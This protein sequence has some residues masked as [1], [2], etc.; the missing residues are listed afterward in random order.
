MHARLH[1]VP[2]RLGA[3]AKHK[4]AARWVGGCVL[5]GRE[6]RE[7]RR[8][9]G[10]PTCR[11]APST[12]S[13]VCSVPPKRAQVTAS[14]GAAPAGAPARS[15]MRSARSAPTSQAVLPSARTRTS[16]NEC[17]PGGRARVAAQRCPARHSSAGAAP[18]CQA[19]S[20]GQ[21]PTT[22][23]WSPCASWQCGTSKETGMVSAGPPAWPPTAAVLGPA[24]G[25][26]AKAGC[27]CAIG[28]SPCM[29][30]RKQKHR[31][32]QAGHQC[33]GKGGRAE[34]VLAPTW[35]LAR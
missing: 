10:G 27:C 34:V 30:A 31:C 16:L 2:P 28:A 18:T 26:T 9:C 23:R 12:R 29:N 22:L 11:R 14:S 13:A 35:R 25:T 6:G 19:P 32:G 5:G 20:A 17:L 21:L 1:R 7:A 8:L 15:G 24:V 4:H 3:S 33:A